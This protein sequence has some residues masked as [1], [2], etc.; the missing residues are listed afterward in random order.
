MIWMMK[1]GDDIAA[2]VGG[3]VLAIYGQLSFS[4]TL[5]TIVYAFLGGFI[6]IFAKKLGESI[7]YAIFPSKENKEEEEN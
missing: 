7:W 5:E 2:A 6:G 1:H 3:I 4:S